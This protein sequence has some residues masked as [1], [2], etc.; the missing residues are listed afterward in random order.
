[1]SERHPITSILTMLSL[2]TMAFAKRPIVG[3]VEST[4]KCRNGKLWNPKMMDMIQTRTLK[5]N[6][7]TGRNGGSSALKMSDNSGSSWMEKNEKG[8]SWLE[9]DDEPTRS[10]FRDNFRGTRVFVQGIPTNVSWQT[11]RLP[12][13]NFVIYLYFLLL[14]KLTN[15]AFLFLL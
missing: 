3:F 9:S 13:L 10:T 15:F 2:L 1:M 6:P 11:V 5:I 12:Q 4:L 8:S 14:L 7:N